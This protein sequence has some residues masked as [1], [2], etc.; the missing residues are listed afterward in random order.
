MF[1]CRCCSAD[2][3]QP[4][5]SGFLLN[6]KVYYFECKNCGYTQTETPT[7]L[8]KAYASPINASDTGILVRNQTNIKDV[9]ATLML[10]GMRQGKVIDYAGGYGFLVRM[11][12]DAGVNAFWSDPYASN[13]VSLGFEYSGDG[14]GDLITAFE[15]FEHFVEPNNEIEKMLSIAPNILFSTELIPIPAPKVDQ[16]WYYG[17]D[18]GQHIGFFRLRTLRYLAKRYN[19]NLLSDSKSL[20]LFTEKKASEVTWKMWRRLARLNQNI[21]TLGIKSKTWSD[22]DLVKGKGL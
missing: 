8:D 22:L 7:W 4:E 21:L 1:Q 2:I 16:W 5:F 9:L 6:K 3:H 19:K 12:R 20:H 14:G 15:V 18:H 10:L 17:A 11:L 13:L